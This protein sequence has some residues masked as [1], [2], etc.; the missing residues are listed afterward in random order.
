MEFRSSSLKLSFTVNERESYEGQYA[1][2]N[3][4]VRSK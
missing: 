2:E 1:I 3:K 4:S